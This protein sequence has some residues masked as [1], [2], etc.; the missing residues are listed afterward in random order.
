MTENVIRLLTLSQV[1]YKIVLFYLDN[2]EY[3][4]LGIMLDDLLKRENLP[5]VF[6]DYLQFFITLFAF[7]FRNKICS[8][9]I[10]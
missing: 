7:Y 8:I 3:V 5:R 4:S 9:L 10:C 1:E 6:F 2:H